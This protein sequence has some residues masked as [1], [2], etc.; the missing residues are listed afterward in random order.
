V[1]NLPVDL[2]SGPYCC[3]AEWDILCVIEASA[4]CELPAPCPG[5]LNGG[6]VV[7][8]Q[9]LIGLITS[10]GSGDPAADLNGDGVVNV[11]DL[12][13]LLVHWGVCA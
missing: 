12:I 5:D 10:W 8:V 4:V 6:G 13:L 9:D 7:S 2:A 3:L 1:R 11:Q